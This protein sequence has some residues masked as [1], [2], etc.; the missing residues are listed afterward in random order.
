MGRLS[1]SCYNDSM[2]G[3]PRTYTAMKNLFDSGLMTYRAQRE[4]VLP[5][6][7]SNT[8]NWSSVKEKRG[9]LLNGSSMLP[10][11]LRRK[12]NC[13]ETSSLVV[14]FGEMVIDYAYHERNATYNVVVGI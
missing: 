4:H 7:K 3:D 6:K 10:L 9:L 5:K 13:K 14:S 8:I 2:R 1:S 12:T 11:L